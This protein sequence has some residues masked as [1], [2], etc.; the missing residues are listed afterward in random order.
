V[1]APNAQGEAALSTR[2]E[3]RE[4]YMLEDRKMMMRLFPELFGE[5]RVA[6]VAHYP[7]LLLETPLRASVCPPRPAGIWW[8]SHRACTTQLIS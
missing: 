5:H 8:C 6:P 2:V 1:R 7:D 3:R 4:S